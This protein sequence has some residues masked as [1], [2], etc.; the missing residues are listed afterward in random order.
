MPLMMSLTTVCAPKPTA[1]PTTPAP[2]MSGPISMPRAESAISPAMTTMTTRRMLR[3][4][5]SKVRIRAC[6]TAASL[7]I[8]C[9]PPVSSSFAAITALTT[10]QMK[11]ATMS[12]TTLVRAPRTRRVAM[13]SRSVRATTSTRQTWASQ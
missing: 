6:R 13:V 9:G 4:I 3:K 5:G 11:S 2:A 1:T 8:V 10:C 12:T 7:P